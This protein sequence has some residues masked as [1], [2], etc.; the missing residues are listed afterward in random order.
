MDSNDGFCQNP[1]GEPVRAIELLKRPE[2][3]GRTLLEAG[4]AAP[5]SPSTLASV[6]VEVK[7]SGYVARERARAE[8]L[9]NQAEVELAE[10]LDYAGMLTLSGEAREKLMRV[11]PMSVAQAGRIP[12]VSPADLQNLVMELR[13]KG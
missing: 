7:Y 6:E 13:R 11:R 8:T 9:R 3:S 4:G 5:P 12:G 10:D 1:V 2:V